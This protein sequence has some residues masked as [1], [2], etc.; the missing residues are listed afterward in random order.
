MSWKVEGLAN[1][2][3]LAE[4]ERRLVGVGDEDVGVG[5][6]RAERLE[7]VARPGGGHVEEGDRAGLPRPG[8]AL[9]QAVGVEL[10]ED[11]EVADVQHPRRRIE[12]LVEVGGGEVEVGADGVDESA[13]LAADVDDQGLAGL[14]LGVDRSA[15]DIHAV[16][17]ERLG[18]EPAED[19][20]AHAGTDRHADAQPRQVDRRVGR[21]AADVE[22]QVIDRHEL[23]RAGQPG[24]RGSHM[25]DDDH[26]RAGDRRPVEQRLGRGHG[27]FSEWRVAS[28][29]TATMAIPVVPTRTFASDSA[30]LT[31]Y[32]LATAPRHCRSRADYRARRPPDRHAAPETAGSAV[33]E[34]AALADQLGDLGL[35]ED[36]ALDQGLGQA[37][38]LVAMLFEQAVG[39]LVGLAEDP[40]DFLVDDLLHVL[41]VVA[42]LGHLAAEE[43]VLGRSS[44]NETGPTRSL[45]PHWVTIFRTSR[46]ACSRSIGGAGAEV[47]VDQALGGPAAHAGCR[48][49]P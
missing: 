27:S 15:V 30:E 34:A 17:H 37:L 6:D 28:E 5:Q 44:R 2:V 11:Q 45:M 8:E 16:G 41:G 38:E 26:P 39:M 10:G 47:V 18:G 1:R 12:D 40:A 14:T 19:V 33:Q 31:D 7:V 20:V 21:P 4:D 24:N 9:G 48:A 3:V 42:G 49:W 25:V 13:V 46:V 36:L 32:A 29:W 22:H 35:G 43:R 23:P